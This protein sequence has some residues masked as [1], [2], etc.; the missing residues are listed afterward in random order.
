MAF[1]FVGLI[2]YW[3]QLN[4]A[5]EETAYQN[6]LVADAQSVEIQ[7]SGRQDLE[8]TKLREV[9]NKLAV[10]RNV[11]DGTLPNLPEVAAGLDRLW[12]RL[13]WIDADN[14]VQA[15]VSRKHSSLIAP[16]DNLKIQSGGQAEHF[17][18]PVPSIDGKSG[19]QL[20]A[21]YEIADLL[22]STDLAWL[23]RRYQ[24]D[25]LSE[26]GEVI[27]T[28]AIPGRL[29]HGTQYEKPLTSF[30]DATLRL[31]PFDALVS[32]HGNG[33]TLSL[34]FG[35]LLLGGAGSQLLR[36]EMAQVTRAIALS[37]TEAAWR[38]S[39]EDSALVGLRAR[40]PSGRILYV[41][42]T[43]CSMVG[44][45]REELIGLIPPLPFWPP[46]AIDG[47]MARNMN[48]LAGEAPNGGYETRWKH[49]DGQFLDVMIFESP[50]VNSDGIPIG[51]MG[52]IVDISERKLLEEKERLHVEAMA[53]HARLND[54][55][56]IASELAHEIN[57]PLTAIAS[58]SAGLDIAIQKQLPGNTDLIS[59]VDAIHRNAKKAGDIVN[60]IRQQS[61]R[62]ESTRVA[63]NLNILVSESLE[64][65]RRQIERKQVH[66]LLD[67][68]SEMPMVRVD[69]IGI[70]Q[71]IANLV[72]NAADALEVHNAARTIWISTRQISDA[73][74]NET[75]LEVSVRDCGAGLQG[76]TIDMLCS[77]FYST[78]ANGM[79]LGLGICRAIVE[80][81]GGKLRAND[82]PDGG[83]EISFT[84]PVSM[85]A[86]EKHL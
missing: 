52:S 64:Q 45:S 82:V 27:A 60:W 73:S 49:R 74:R 13:V 84:L 21:R 36:W 42:K 11:T 39:M 4:D 9:A 77:T 6:T 70:E 51:W 31:T 75:S 78:K 19:G 57:Q 37:Q 81:H 41:N 26:L 48:T 18:V 29:A 22:Q 25:F 76:R 1:V 69:R 14:Q 28:T 32:W 54:M 30:K 24:V 34:L 16:S 63:C 15:R 79:G 56:L 65:R 59:A 10:H 61:S 55:G 43:L 85:H 23:N 86:N 5:L 83:A 72:R 8:R 47:M 38:Q 66:V 68:A 80:S 71:V 3:A 20:L 7:L 33:R 35:L 67:L 53:Q 62:S 50:L 40:D 17:V 46:E 12:N 58:Y 44:Y 2:V